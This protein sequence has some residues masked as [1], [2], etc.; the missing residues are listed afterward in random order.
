MAVRLCEALPVLEVTNCSHQSGFGRRL[1][2]R[3]GLKGVEFVVKSRV[4]EE[5]C[6][7]EDG[8]W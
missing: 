2:V 1:T 7:H 6:C 3:S 5:E 8:V 4:S